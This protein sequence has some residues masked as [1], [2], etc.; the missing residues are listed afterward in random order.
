MLVHVHLKHGGFTL[1]V[2]SVSCQMALAHQ[3]A[4]NPIFFSIHYNQLT[5]S[6][7]RD[8]TDRISVAEN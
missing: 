2:S 8:K 1:I 5:M 3:Q 6:C 7:A 4:G